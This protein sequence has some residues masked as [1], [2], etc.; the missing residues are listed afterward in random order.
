[1]YIICVVCAC[2]RA[3]A[4][5]CKCVCMRVYVCV[6]VSISYSAEVSYPPAEALWHDTVCT[7]EAGL[8]GL[9]LGGPTTLTV[10]ASP[11]QAHL[12]TA[13]YSRGPYIHQAAL[14]TLITHQACRSWPSLVVVI[15]LFAYNS[16]TDMYPLASM[17][18]NLHPVENVFF[19]YPCVP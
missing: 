2:V 12:L 4:C 16:D 9:L 18:S 1:M 7:A 19:S 17:L 3:C 11:H 5:A 15:W 13:A 14:L 8:R 10:S 6:C